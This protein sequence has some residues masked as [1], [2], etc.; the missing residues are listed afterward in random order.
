MYC[1]V[2]STTFSYH[3]GM[4]DR[5][6]EVSNVTTEEEAW[7]ICQQIINLMLHRH[8]VADSYLHCFR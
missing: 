4:F 8:S 2:F 3:I 1:N 6:R 5:H 7:T